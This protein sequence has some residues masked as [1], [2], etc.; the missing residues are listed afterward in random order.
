MFGNVHSLMAGIP[1]WLFWSFGTGVLLSYPFHFVK[2]QVLER[3]YFSPTRSTLAISGVLN[4]C[5]FLLP[6]PF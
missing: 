2:L 5:S 6:V 4:G 3:V 1:I